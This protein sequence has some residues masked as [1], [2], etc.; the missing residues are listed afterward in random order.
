M[1]VSHSTNNVAGGGGSKFLMDST[2]SSFNSFHA[3]NQFKRQPS[4]S[5]SQQN[6]LLQKSTT[7]VPNG[8]QQQQQHAVSD[9]TRVSRMNPKQI[10]TN[11][12]FGYYDSFG[13]AASQPSRPTNFPTKT[14]NL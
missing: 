14:P 3:S 5:Q 8:Q 13:L 6:F 1:P 4:F 9:S 11:S 12:V 10:V 7:P 2:T